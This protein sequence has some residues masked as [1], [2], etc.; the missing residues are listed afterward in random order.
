MKQDPFKAF[1]GK[2]EL[3]HYQ[4]E[5]YIRGGIRHV[6]YVTTCPYTREQFEQAVEAGTVNETAL[7]AGYARYG[8]VKTRFAAMPHGGLM[9][10][11][12]ERLIADEWPEI[13]MALVPDG[14]RDRDTFKY[15]DKHTD[16]LWRLFVYGCAYSHGCTSE[17]PEHPR[18]LL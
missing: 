14:E 18:P 16:H 3:E 5:D 2:L 10:Q 1:M 15:V 7:K 4:R 12:F 9:Q 13:S 8:R 11:R 6:K 17:P